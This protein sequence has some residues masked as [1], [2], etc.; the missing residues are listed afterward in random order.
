VRAVRTS[1]SVFSSLYAAMMA[2]IPNRFT[3]NECQG[4]RFATG[5]P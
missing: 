5:R 2:D 1:A 4:A 3:S